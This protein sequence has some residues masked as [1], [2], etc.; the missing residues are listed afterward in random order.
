MLKVL[1]GTPVGIMSLI[2][3]VGTCVV[4]S[5]WLYFTFKKHDE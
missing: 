5:Y 2:T 4:I 1:F 3:V